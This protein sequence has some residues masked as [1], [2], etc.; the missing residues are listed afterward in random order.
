MIYVIAEYVT[1][2]GK[3]IAKGA[4]VKESKLLSDALNPPM[5]IVQLMPSMLEISLLI[6]EKGKFTLMSLASTNDLTSTSIKMDCA[7]FKMSKSKD[8]VFVYVIDFNV[9]FKKILQPVQVHHF[10]RKSQSTP[11]PKRKT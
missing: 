2:F 5:S 3:M 8:F 9:T 7:P 10:T 11:E 6:M 4:L 1:V